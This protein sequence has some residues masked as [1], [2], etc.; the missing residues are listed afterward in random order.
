MLCQF[1]H[2]SR[3]KASFIGLSFVTTSK[4][5]WSTVCRAII[6]QQLAIEVDRVEN[7]SLCL[8]QFGERWRPGDSMSILKEAR[9]TSSLSESEQQL[10]ELRV[11]L[12]I[13]SPPAPPNKFEEASVGNL[14]LIDGRLNRIKSECVT[15]WA[16][17]SEENS[18]GFMRKLFS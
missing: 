18:S 13:L 11:A 1:G 5:K 6:I 16:P 7:N 4:L 10:V 14:P 9:S 8:R 2:K 12:S 3:K 17:H 15:N